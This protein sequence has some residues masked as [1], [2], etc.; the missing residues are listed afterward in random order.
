M[1]QYIYCISVTKFN[2]ENEIDVDY[3]TNACY[4]SLK[5]ACN[6]LKGISKISCYTNVSIEKENTIDMTLF[7][8][9]ETGRRTIEGIER[10]LLF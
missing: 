4:T 7:Y 3:I 10:K 2:K 8:T 9:D 5:K 6:E 1:K